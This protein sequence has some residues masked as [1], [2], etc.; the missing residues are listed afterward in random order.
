MRIIPLLLVFSLFAQDN[1]NIPTKYATTGSIGTVTLN[2]QVYNQLSIRPE[3]PIGKL[4]VGLDIYLYF[5]DEG[6]YWDSWDF[7]SGGSAYKTIIDKIYYLRWGQPGD[8]IYFMAGALPS[9]TLGQGILVNNYANIM[10]YPQVRQV[11]LNL[12]AK[13]AGFGIE[14][15]HSNFKS[16]TPGILGIRGSRSIL[17]KLS[18]GVSFVTDLNQLSGLPNSDG[19]N[20]PDY[21]DFYPG[22]ENKWDDSTKAR[23]E[24]DGFNNFLLDQGKDPLS[25]SKFMVWFEESKYY[26]SY[27]PFEAISDPVSGLAIDATYSLSEKMTLYSQFGLLKGEIA[28]PE[29]NSKMVDLGWGLVPIGV[30]AQLGPV[31]LLAEYRMG[32]RRF[33]FNYWDRAY[34]VN[35]VSIINSDTGAE[36]AT[37]ESQ[38]YLYGELNGFYAQ[39]EM[40]VMNLFTLSSGYQNMQGEKWDEIAGGYDPDKSNSTFLST[41]AINPSL[42][43]KVG[44]AEAFYQQ[45]NVLNPFDFSPTSSTIW[46]YNVGVEVSSGVMLMYKARTTYISDLENEGEFIPVESIQ[47]ETQFIF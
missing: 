39:A 31:N 20:Y 4:G 13:V 11:G 26:N 7:S 33:V 28:D 10:E 46:G 19:D 22:D 32:S 37:R 25:D 41:I 40:S 47:I 9:V 30:R 5:N 43:P 14:L 35:R 44:K 18:L 34:D 29:D 12:Q 38:L 24:W 27:N 21:Y 16:A 6:M 45:S 23:I 3:I 17:S 15:I 1:A 8:N 36:V 42:I 2:G